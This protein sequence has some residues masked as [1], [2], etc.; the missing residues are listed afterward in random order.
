MEQLRAFIAVELPTG[1]RESLG[2]ILQNLQAV[3]PVG[4]R[5]VRP[6]GIHLTLKF[7]G[8][9]GAE[10]VGPISQDMSRC[11][12]SINPFDLFLSELGAFPS[13]RA[14]RVI[15]IGLGGAMD[16]LLGLQVSLEGELERLGYARERRPFS[17]HLTLGRTRE[18]MPAPQRR[19]VGDDLAR[20]SVEISE[21]LPVKEIALIQSTLTP[22]GAIYTR[23]FSASLDRNG[24]KAKLS[25]QPMALGHPGEITVKKLAKC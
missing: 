25:R 3:V 12:A 13:L 15:W 16:A 19:G 10:S 17:P 1:A 8:N 14:P 22:S 11:A 2:S 9:I 21:V 6:E 5:W 4:V 23:L 24:N 7:L 20:A 18:G